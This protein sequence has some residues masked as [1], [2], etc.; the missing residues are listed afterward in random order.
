VVFRWTVEGNGFAVRG[1][2][3]RPAVAAEATV[4]PG[5]CARLRLEAEQDDRR[6]VAEA[7]IQAVEPPPDEAGFG[8]PEPHLVDAPG[9][10]KLATSS[11]A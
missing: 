6:A 10:P 1:E 2:G 5:A 4:R 8:I 11:N 3:S 7:A 9:E